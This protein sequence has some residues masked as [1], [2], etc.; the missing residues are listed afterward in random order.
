MISN[1]TG[2]RQQ[3]ST[4]PDRTAE[5]AHQLGSKLYRDGHFEGAVNAFSEAI[6]LAP[7]E[8]RYRISL[9]AALGRL[10][11]HAEAVAQLKAALIHRG[12][13]LAELHN[14][15]GASLQKLGRLDEAAAALANA[16]AL[17][18]DYPE[19][20]RNLAGVLRQLGRTMATVAAYEAILARHPHD[21]ESL[22]GLS[23]ALV[24]A[25]D[26]TRAIEVGRKLVAA[27]PS[28]P[29]ARSA[30]IYTLH[31]SPDHD[32]EAIY[33]ESVEWGR[34]FCDPL[35]DSIPPHENDRD[36]ERKLKVGFVSPDLREHTV[37]KFV[38]AFIRHHEREQFEVG[39]Y[40]DAERPD[41]V[42]E[43]IKGWAEHFY[44]TRGLSTSALERLIREHRI[45]IL[46]DLR[47]H[48][49]DNRLMLFARRPAP[50]QMNMV[51][52]FNTTGLRAMTHRIADSHM[53]PAGTE[54]LNTEQLV[55]I[56]P[57]R[58]CYTPEA[59][60]PPVAESPVLKN[61][62]ITFGS[63]NKAVK[64]SEPCA[65][66]WAKVL[67]AVPESKLLLTAPAEAAASVRQRLARL[68]LP[69]DRIILQ[70][71]TRT[72]REYLERYNEI[73]IVL[74][75][76]P[77]GGM[78]V[79]CDGL[80]MGVPCVSLAGRTPAGRAGKSILHAAELPELAAETEDQFVSVGCELARDVDR[81]CLLRSTMRER[82]MASP[83]MDQA[84]FAR[85]LGAEF[86]KMWRGWCVG[87]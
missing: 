26:A 32:A 35:Q 30:L 27:D 43:R 48:G 79:T 41:H 6:R 52:Y 33:R 14:N 71:K 68:G 4:A 49:A 15:L 36:P 67:D 39:C 23:T 18:D 24:E 69:A 62:F 31:Y 8:P 28:S 70:D 61:G 86:R 55:R 76:L 45:D 19:A 38:S 13:G 22:W 72:S 29:A 54:R 82:L 9:A 58:W 2:S 7:G 37:T 73:D 17:R 65:K 11:R 20:R 51:G 44:D 3:L 64:V 34:L 84:G 53:D 80:W 57:S 50:L 40:S 46:V 87:P 1:T 47:G 10:G 63:L 74:D 77:F 59:D 42:T 81:L 56:E 66:L 16:L 60:E 78:T 5:A 25:A 83:L 75:T 12:G 21:R 85:K